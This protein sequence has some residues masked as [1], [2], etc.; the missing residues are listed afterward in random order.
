ML[1]VML[2]KPDLLTQNTHE[3]DIK[4]VQSKNRKRSKS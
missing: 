3:V 4:F 1:D 2:T